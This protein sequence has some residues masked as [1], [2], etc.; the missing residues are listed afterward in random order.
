MKTLLVI[1]TLF[2]ILISGSI[3]L[4]NSFADAPT[5]VL[6]AGIKDN[7]GSW[8]VGEGLKKGD[9][10][11]YDLCFVYYKDC[12]EFQMDFWVE[13]DLIVETETKWLVQVVVYD[14]P[15]VV[16][17]N[18][19]LGKIAPEP[20]GGSKDIGPYRSAF[21]S[22]II[23]LSA[24]AN[25]DKP[26]E[27]SKPSW[28]KIANIGGQQIIPTEMQ[29]I[30]VPEGT[31]DTA[32]ISWRTG[33]QDSKVWV[34]DGFPFPIKAFT[35]VHVSSGI[36]PTEY[37]F[38]LLDYKENVLVN[39]FIGIEPKLP[40]AGLEGCLQNY[41]LVDVKRP[42]I[43][44]AYILDVKYGPPNPEIGCEIEW[45]IGFKSKFSETEFLSQVQYDI[46]VV[47]ENLTPLRSL[48]QEEGKQFL[49]APS[50]FVH[51]NT[52][53]KENPG[54]AHYVIW[55]YGTSPKYIV[56]PPEELDYLQIDIPIA[57]EQTPT[58]T[59]PRVPSWIKT[60]A[61]FWVDGFSSDNEFVNAIEFLINEGVIVIP[62]IASG[63]ETAAK[64]PS[65]IQTTTGFWVDGFTSDEEL[66]SAIQWL[67]ENG[68]M[69]I[70]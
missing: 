66:V 1:L 39:P 18:M 54:T 24:F 21:K 67:I 25:A 32:L 59:S 15:F 27:F 12:T 29:T 61:G 65:W 17:G 70:A 68:I 31:F 40:G 51:T 62:P 5:E 57:G 53:V 2:V 60:T 44:F 63:G 46:L 38:E 69:R 19:E 7:P 26:K 9:F 4:Q 48:A 34:L 6:T 42:T 45:F 3:P 33:G 13:G 28:G 43:G 41:E 52:I 14:G 64:I 11:S 37:E 8:W 20:T 50:G 47:D 49:Y 22:S 56:A 35:Y 58:P 10:F 16:P 36:P 55:L 23:W 30:T